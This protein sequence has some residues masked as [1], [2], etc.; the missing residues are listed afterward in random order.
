MT[1]VTPTSTLR[2][3]S[4]TD[5]RPRWDGVATVRRAR[6]ARRVLLALFTVF[7]LLGATG[8]LGVRSGAVAAAG[9][10]YELTVDYAKVTRPGHAAPFKVTVRKAGGFG[11]DPIELRV[12]ADYFDLF[13]E[14][15]TDPDA[16]KATADDRYVYLEFDPPEGEVFVMRTDTRTGPNRQR[17]KAATVS[18][19]TD[20][21]PAV[22]VELRTR[23]MP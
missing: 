10:G 16:S 23:V 11:D 1:I 15:S 12:T 5:T 19:M 21:G 14:N 18:V 20:A 3:T 9:G 6:L 22:S 17:G 7:L 8:V 4:P 2:P 13:D